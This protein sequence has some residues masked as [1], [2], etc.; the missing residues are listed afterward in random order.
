MDARQLEVIA[1]LAMPFSVPVELQSQTPEP[2]EREPLALFLL[3]D[4]SNSMGYQSEGLR[5]GE[6]FRIVDYSDTVSVPEHLE[7]GR[8]GTDIYDAADR[9]DV[10]PEAI[11][12]IVFAYLQ[13]GMDT[14]VNAIGSALYL[15]AQHPDQW[16]QVRS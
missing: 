7:P 5:A 13:A 9:G 15:F 6:S 10:E 4:R 12:G 1:E 11:H 2:E 14:T 8:W 16:D 3:V